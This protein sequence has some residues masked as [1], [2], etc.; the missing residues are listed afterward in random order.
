MHTQG[1]RPSYFALVSG[2]SFFS[3]RV[4]LLASVLNLVSLQILD[5]SRS[6][7]TKL[8]SKKNRIE[9]LEYLDTYRVQTNKTTNKRR[10]NV[11]NLVKT[12]LI[13]GKY[14]G[15]LIDPNILCISKINN[16]LL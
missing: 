12:Q 1:L 14:I 5:L 2:L 7:I 4:E 10:S 13:T 16:V 3:S 9:V 8:L 11:S 15:I 6:R